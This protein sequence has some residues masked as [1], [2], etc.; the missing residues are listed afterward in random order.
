MAAMNMVSAGGF[1][2][3]SFR[4]RRCPQGIASV[5]CKKIPI[6][7]SGRPKL[8]HLTVH[9]SLCIRSP[10]PYI[11]L[12]IWSSL[13]ITDLQQGVR[14]PPVLQ[15]Q[16]FQPLAG[17]P[18]NFLSLGFCF[19]RQLDVLRPQRRRLGHPLPVAANQ[20]HFDPIG[21]RQLLEDSDQCAVRQVFRHIQT[22]RPTVASRD[23][24]SNIGVMVWRWIWR[25]RWR[26]N[27]H[28]FYTT[29]MTFSYR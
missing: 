28:S 5:L 27:K 6:F 4:L 15:H 17:S 19:P 22:V 3:V 13:T 11:W 2:R 8:D 14:V 9:S 25:N 12:H 24:R 18:Q 29:T 16:R 10:R 26:E 1:S 7:G 21:E 23:D 20:L